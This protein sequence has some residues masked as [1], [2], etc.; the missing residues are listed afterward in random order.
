MSIMLNGIDILYEDNHLLVAV[1]PPNMPT[2]SDP[3][4]DM[5]ML[6]A[7]KEGLRLRENKPGEAYLG[8]V[9][10]M[11][12]PVGGVIAFA[13]TSKAAARLSEQLRG[14]TMRRGYA[15]VV[16][17]HTEKSGALQDYLKKDQR[18]NF[19]T[20]VNEGA[21]DAQYAAL[22]FNRIGY[23]E[24]PE[25]VSLVEITL[26]TGRSHQIR[27]Q[28]QN[29]GHPLWGDYKYGAGRIGQRIAL[30]GFEL[31]LTHPTLKKEM[32]FVSPPPVWEPWD[33]FQ[34]DLPVWK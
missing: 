18:T 23:I 12:R 15:A 27:V 16:R 10:R 24:E 5:D 28:F 19:V 22:R 29:A 13:K 30:W 11:D 20:V 26:E 14:H 4:G 7:L 34:R 3:S 25:P 1:K 6:T 2:Q 21:K 33:R 17:G 31:A 8:L 9:H 32:R